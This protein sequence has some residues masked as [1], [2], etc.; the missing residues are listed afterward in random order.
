MA[1]PNR[2]DVLTLDLGKADIRLGWMDRQTV[3]LKLPGRPFEFGCF[4]GTSPSQ[5]VSLA[6]QQMVESVVCFGFVGSTA[7][8]VP[9][10]RQPS[11]ERKPD[12]RSSCAEGGKARD[13][14]L[15][16]M[17]GGRTAYITVTSSN[18][19]PLRKTG[20]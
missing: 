2:E 11:H 17:G 8:S 6:K 13:P 16:S 1:V 4:N 7:G 12:L 14:D 19:N 5:T 20:T 10:T 3:P 18:T 15:I 9:A